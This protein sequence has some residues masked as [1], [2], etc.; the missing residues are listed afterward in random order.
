[1]RDYSKVSPSV[2]H[3]E[4]FNSLGSDDARYTYIY[5]LTCSHQTSAGCYFLPTAYAAADLRW[6]VERY[7]RALSELISASLISHDAAANVVRITRWFKFN[8]PMND[9]H[10]KGIRHI[11][12]RLPSQKIWAE[13]TA[14]LDEVMTRA[15]KAMAEKEAKQEAGGKAPGTSWAGWKPRAA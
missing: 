10:L 15:A 3:S 2:W 5:L 9:K 6:P 4:R 12:E 7:Q 8:A 1:M 11:L 14:E 13:A